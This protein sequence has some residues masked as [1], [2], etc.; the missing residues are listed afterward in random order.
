MRSARVKPLW[1]L[2]LLGVGAA[3]SM[4]GC[5]ASCDCDD[6]GSV[7]RAID[8]VGDEVEDVVDKAKEKKP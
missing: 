8:E 1:F 6:R 5:E 3:G 7:E 2:G 4:G